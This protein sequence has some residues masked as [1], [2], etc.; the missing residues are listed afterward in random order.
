MA[1]FVSSRLLRPGGRGGSRKGDPDGGRP[2]PRDPRR[3]YERRKAAWAAKYTT[4]SALRRTFGPNR[5]RLWGDLDPP[6]TRRLYHTLLPRALLE[7]RG[8]RDGLVGCAE[9]VLGNSTD[10]S[11]G[12][13]DAVA[14]DESLKSELKSLAPLA[15]RARSAAKAY[16]R[17]RSRLPGR[18]GSMLYDG[19][20]SWRRYG[21]FRPGGMTWEQV[22]S[23]YEEQ[24]LSE[25]AGGLDG[26]S[27]PSGTDGGGERAPTDDEITARVCLRILERSVVTNTAIDRLFLRRLAEAEGEG[28]RGDGLRDVLSDDGRRSRRRSRRALRARRRRARRIAEDLE[29]IEREFDADVREL[30]RDGDLT[31]EAGERRR[32]TRGVFWRSDGGEGGGPAAVAGGGPDEANA[33]GDMNA[34]EGDGG[35]PPD[36][37]GGEDPEKRGG[38]RRLSV[39]EVF[40]LRILASTKQRLSSLQSKMNG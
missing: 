20:R 38:G 13:P 34:I 22:W 35:T 17:E 5:N 4:A 1:R 12:A 25:S 16:A 29:R 24:V 26:P 32:V 23:K 27:P 40:A 36:G 8:V 2:S 28:E 7:L 10:G 19:L 3:D 39:S 31:S 37:R 11:A 18:V 33:D 30:L 9:S 21:T 15:F 14:S 6:A